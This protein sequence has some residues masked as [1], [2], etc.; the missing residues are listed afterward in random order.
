M[1]TDEEKNSVLKL[2]QLQYSQLEQVPESEPVLAGT[3]L[4]N[5]HP[6]VVLFDSGASFTFISKAYA[7]KHRYEITELKQKY[8][9]TAA[10]SSI[11]TNHIVRDLR[12]QVGKES[13][14]ISPLVLPRLGIDVILGMEW[15]KQH[16]AMIDVE[17]R[18]V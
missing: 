4:V 15:L 16:N 6:T 12:L 13:L 8:S 17:S 9:I 14:F 11:N 5:D 1:P 2:G 3:F 10:G 18:T 7:L